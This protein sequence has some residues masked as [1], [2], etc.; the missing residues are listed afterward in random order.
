MNVAGG[1]VDVF[2]LFMLAMLVNVAAL[3]WACGIACASARFR[4]GR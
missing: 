3:L 1:P 4:P 2:G